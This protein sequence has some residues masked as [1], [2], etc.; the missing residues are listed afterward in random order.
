VYESPVRTGEPGAR[1][2]LSGRGAPPTVGGMRRT[3]G[4][5]GRG[6]ITIGLLILLFVAYMLWGTG[7]YT[8]RQQNELKSQFHTEL[9]QQPKPV[10]TAP[11]VP[12][13]APPEGDVLGEIHIPKIGA[14][15]AIVEGTSRDDLRKGPGHYPTTPLPGQRGNS[16]IAGHRTT[17]LAPF[18][19]LDELT[20]GDPIIVATRAGTYRYKMTQQLVV[21]PHDV[22]VL[23]QTPNA[24]LTLT[25]CNPKYSA[26]QRLVVKAVLDPSKSDRVTAPATHQVSTKSLDAG[27]EGQSSSELPVYLWGLIAA[28]VGALWWFLF[29]RWKRWYVWIAGAIPFLAVLF[30]FYY[31]LERALPNGY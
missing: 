7:L 16:A 5:V 2:A 31:Y 18:N 14:N 21:S 20:P 1:G 4:W 28:A 23:D 30:V 9:K 8:A 13:T 19:R 12:L 3:L 10:K 17:Y 27:L 29:H 15:F 22:Y 25:T 6:L 26:R 24:Q 11:A